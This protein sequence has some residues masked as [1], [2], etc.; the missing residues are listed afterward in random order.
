MKMQLTKKQ[1]EYLRSKTDRAILAVYLT[2]S[3]LNGIQVEGS[4]IDFYVVTCPEIE[5]LVFNQKLTG[6]HTGKI[7]FK[8]ADLFHF[9]KLI[10]KSNPNMIEMFYHEPL[11]QHPAY[12]KLGSW[13]TSNRDELPMINPSGWTNALIGQ[14]KGSARSIAKGKDYQGN[15]S[16]GKD[17]IQFMKAFSYLS[18]YYEHRSLDV[19]FRGAMHVLATKVKSGRNKLLDAERIESVYKLNDTLEMVE[20]RPI[21]LGDP[22]MELLNGLLAMVKYTFLTFSI[23]GDS[24]K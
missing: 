1:I 14:M 18:D 3:Y 5:D 4:D 9:A 16:A 13:L 10:C 12:K 22:D 6:Q 21:V 15:G 23:W 24:F 8:T 2:G 11:Y 17:L 20:S 19:V 7:D